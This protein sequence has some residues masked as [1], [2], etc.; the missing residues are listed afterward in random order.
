MTQPA[1]GQTGP[2]GAPGGPPRARGAGGP[3]RRPGAL[4]SRGR[5]DAGGASTDDAPPIGSDPPAFL[6]YD[7][8]V[9]RL[10]ERLRSGRPG[11]GAPAPSKRE[12]ADGTSGV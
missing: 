5:D 3:G 1:R 6:R 4:V 2:A 7:A 12:R 8:V 10:A 9:V 11:G